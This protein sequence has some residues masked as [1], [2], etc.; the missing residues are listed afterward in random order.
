MSQKKK[1]CKDNAFALQTQNQNVQMG[2]LVGTVWHATA[3]TMKYVTKTPDSV[4]MANVAEVGALVKMASVKY[5]TIELFSYNNYLIDK[6][7]KKRH[8]ESLKYGVKNNKLIK[9]ATL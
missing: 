6:L 8:P 3:H 1:N 7:K 5:V 9:V 4:L 2:T